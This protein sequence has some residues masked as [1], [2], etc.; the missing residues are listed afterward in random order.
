MYPEN[1]DILVF[2]TLLS[3]PFLALIIAALIGMMLD[4]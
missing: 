1:T 4:P 2:A 3:A